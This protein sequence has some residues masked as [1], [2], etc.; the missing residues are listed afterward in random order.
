MER[1][2]LAA[3]SAA[4]RRTPTTATAWA[5]NRRPTSTGL[6]LRLSWA[7]VTPAMNATPGFSGLLRACACRVGPF[8]RPTSV[9][10]TAVRATEP[11][12]IRLR[13][14]RSIIR[15]QGASDPRESGVTKERRVI[16]D[17]SGLVPTVRCACVAGQ[18]EAR[19]R[20]GSTSPSR[21][22]RRAPSG[23]SGAGERRLQSWRLTSPSGGSGDTSRN[24]AQT[25]MFCARG[26]LSSSRSPTARRWARRPG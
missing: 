26:W 22:R 8:Q 10:P 25:H 1:T 24:G 21:P 9:L 20:S 6:Q 11:E 12:V 4:G 17:P 3:S 7:A 13:H 14:V 15:G 18:A 2:N 16:V 23:R 5:R 19:L